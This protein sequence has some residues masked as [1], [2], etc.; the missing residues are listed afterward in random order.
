MPFR[1]PI[2]AEHKGSHLVLTSYCFLSKCCNAVVDFLKRKVTL[3]LKDKE[4]TIS[5]YTNVKLEQFLGLTV[6]YLCWF[7]INATPS[8]SVELLVIYT[9]V[10]EI[11]IRHYRLIRL[12]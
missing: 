2:V 7:H 11:R 8:T 9:G 4:C 10:S 1:L 3:I 5:E 6:I 12:T